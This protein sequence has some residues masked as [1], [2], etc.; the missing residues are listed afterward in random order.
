MDHAPPAHPE[1]EDARPSDPLQEALGSDFEI[2]QKLG[3][4]SMATV[5]LA[6]EK[7]LGRLVAVKVLLPERARD[8]TARKRFE[9]EAK[10]AASLSHPN[11]VQVFRLGRL[12]DETPYLVMRFVKG[13]TL[14][15]RLAAEG[16]LPRDL[17]RQV[18]RNVASALAAAH[19]QGIVHRDVRP[20]NVLW[21]EESKQA[22]LA[23]FG[24]AAILAS[25]GEESTRLTKTGQMVGDPRYLSPEQ[26]RDEDLTELSDMYAFGILGYELYT[27]EGPYEA[28]T[29]TQWITAHLSSEPRDL[30]RIRPDIEPEVAALLK[31]CMNREPNHRPSAANAAKALQDTAIGG[32]GGLNAEDATFWDELKRRRF[33]QFVGSAVVVGA[34]F[35][36]FAS[37]VVVSQFGANDLLRPLS[38]PLAVCG[39]AAATV[40][41]WYHGERGTQRSG[42]LER[43]LLVLI[44]VLWLSITAWIII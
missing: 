12:G 31:R 13:R 28:K 14:E 32:V 15:E 18:L 10:A 25:S 3:K 36:G 2:K 17:A 39:V 5:Y 44:G 27:G 34:T 22:L 38:V 41:T 4:G 23:D 40:I 30:E 6:K 16:R 35:V 43:V 21:D 33:P 29:N 7:A 11:V 26:L 20:A 1:P 19:A 42:V 37:E 9:R 8:E 24:I